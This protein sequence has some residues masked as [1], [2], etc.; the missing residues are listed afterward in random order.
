MGD[1]LIGQ[2]LA[3]HRRTQLRKQGKYRR[4]IRDDIRPA[5]EAAY[6]DAAEAYRQTRSVARA[7]ERAQE[8][9]TKIEDPLEKAIREAM[10]EGAEALVDA[11]QRR[12]RSRSVPGVRVTQKDMMGKIRRLIENWIGEHAAR[13]IA[14]I[15]EATREQVRRILKTRERRNEDVEGT[16]AA[17]RSMAKDFGRHRAHRIARTEALSA[18]QAG[19][20]QG[21]QAAAPEAGKRWVDA[22]DDRVR[23]DPRG[24]YPDADFQ[25]HNVGRI[26]GV[27]AQKDRFDVSGEK[28]EH[29]G[30]PRGSPGNVIHCRCVLAFEEPD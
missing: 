5:L 21:A 9:A 11:A 22:G 13:K 15:E 14:G 24:R 4:R 10:E 1:L 30:D 26:N 19:Q 16:A 2:S 7:A 18:M 29:P 12:R 27:I 17:L 6:S 20:S 8:R 28:L 23:G 25:H 3:S